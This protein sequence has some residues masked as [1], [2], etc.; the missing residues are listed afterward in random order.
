[1]PVTRG[2]IYHNLLESK[3]VITNNV[4]TFF[5]SSEFYRSKFLS[6]YKLNRKE[7]NHFF[8]KK[9]SKTSDKTIQLNFDLIS[10]LSLYCQIEKRGFRVLT[11]GGDMT[12]QKAFQYALENLMNK[13]IEDWYVT[14]KQK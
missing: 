4:M 2:G 7:F 14:Q 12:C 3:Y 10:D 9:M 1:M 5:F 11:K 6:D 8:S 13:E